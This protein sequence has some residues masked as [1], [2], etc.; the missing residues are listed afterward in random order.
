[1]AKTIC[2]R[3]IYCIPAFLALFFLVIGSH[4]LH[5]HYH[6]DISTHSDYEVHHAEAESHSNDIAVGISTPGE[7]HSCTICEFLAICSALK[8]ATVHL[9]VRLN[10]VQRAATVDQLSTISSDWPGF[11]IRGPPSI[12]LIS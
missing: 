3:K 11:H 2:S 6:D 8:T 10:P 7:N 5:P 4:S 12:S 9:S 1:M